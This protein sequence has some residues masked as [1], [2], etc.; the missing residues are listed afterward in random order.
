MVVE[1]LTKSKITATRQ[2]VISLSHFYAH[3]TTQP[4]PEWF[5]SSIT[6]ES[7]V[8]RMNSKN[9]D[10]WVVEQNGSIVG[11]AAVK[12]RNHIYHLFVSQK[13]QRKGIATQLWQTAQANTD[14]KEFSL[15][16]SVY[17]IPIYK[18]WG[19][20]E[21]DKVQERDGICYQPMVLSVG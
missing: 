1:P 17:A 13:H 10:Q 9:F 21:S 8:K 2:L 4:T 5:S 15:N 20:I 18:R 11:Y 14:S 16:S 12:N 19:F 3:D 6:E 7:F